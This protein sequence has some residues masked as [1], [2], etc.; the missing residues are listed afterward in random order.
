MNVV[1]SALCGQDPEVVEV[2]LLAGETVAASEAP[3]NAKRQEHVR[4]LDGRGGQTARRLAARSTNS[5]AS[6]GRRPARRRAAVSD[7]HLRHESRFV[8]SAGGF[9]GRAARAG[10]TG[11]DC[12]PPPPRTVQAVLSHTAHRHRSP[13][14]IRS[15]DPR[16]SPP[17]HVAAGD[18][19]IEGRGNGDPDPA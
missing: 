16:P 11:L 2:W 10:P 12:L 9:H 18:L 13:A 6:R 14:G 3:A 1:W 7:C 19:V 8:G 4:G 5:S 15:P 17:W